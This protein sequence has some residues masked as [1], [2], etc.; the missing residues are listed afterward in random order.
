MNRIL[1]VATLVA[2][3]IPCTADAAGWLNFRQIERV[4]FQTGGFF[5]YAERGWDNPNACNKADAIV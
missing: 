1:T 3:L 4:A 5:L 2:L